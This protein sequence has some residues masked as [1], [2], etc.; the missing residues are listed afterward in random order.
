MAS[1]YLCSL[2]GPKNQQPYTF[3]IVQLQELSKSTKPL[4][5][6]IRVKLI[7]FQTTDLINSSYNAPF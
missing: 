5:L 6:Y 3:P 4:F 2:F 1:M 7:S